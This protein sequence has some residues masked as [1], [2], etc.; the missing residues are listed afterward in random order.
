MQLL[1]PLP[2]EFQSY[3]S[4]AGFVTSESKDRAAASAFLAC[5]AAPANAATFAAKG[6]E[7]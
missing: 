2:A 7:R 1:A 4:F 3:I 6:I 5:I